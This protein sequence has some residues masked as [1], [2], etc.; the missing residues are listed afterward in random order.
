MKTYQIDPRTI[1]FNTGRPYAQEGQIIVARKVDE[2]VQFYD[3]TR[4]ITGTMQADL[5]PR[6][7]MLTYDDGDYEPSL[8]FVQ[9]LE[10]ASLIRECR[11]YVCSVTE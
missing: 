4:D 11:E 5:D 3:V 1:I 8:P 2:D 6:S 7:I 10:L 9:R